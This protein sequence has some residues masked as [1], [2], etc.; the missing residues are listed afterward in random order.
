MNRSMTTSRWMRV[1]RL[2]KIRILPWKFRQR[3]LIGLIAVLGPRL[4]RLRLCEVSY[5]LTAVIRKFS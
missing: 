3:F 4:V 1:K 5:M 2:R